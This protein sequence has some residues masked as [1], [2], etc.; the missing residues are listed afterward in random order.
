MIYEHA[1]HILM[2]PENRKRSCKEITSRHMLLHQPWRNSQQ[3]TNKESKEKKDPS[4]HKSG[5]T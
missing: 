5:Q 1:K 3:P 4:F 2:L